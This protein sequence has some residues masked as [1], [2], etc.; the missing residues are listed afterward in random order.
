MGNNRQ[1]ETCISGPCPL[2]EVN[3][4]GDDSEPLR[5][6]HSVVEELQMKLE[7]LPGNEMALVEF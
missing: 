2:V 5:T 3:I 7:T 1:D 6:T 4:I